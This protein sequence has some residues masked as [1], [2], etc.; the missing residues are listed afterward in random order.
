MKSARPVGIGII[1]CGTIAY[2][3]HIRS[4]AGL[5]N[6]RVT[7]LADPDPDALARAKRLVNAPAFSTVEG[8]LASSAIDAVVIAS[9]TPLHPAH[10]LAACAAGKHVYVEK[11]LAHDAA[12]LSAI[13][14]CIEDTKL[15]IAVGYNLRFHPACQRVRQRLGSGSIG[16]IRAIVSHF[17]E[18]TGWVNMPA[19]KRDREHGGGVLLDLGSHHIDLY[20]WFLRDDVRQISANTRSLHSEQDSAMVS[21]TTRGG[22]DLCGYFAF[23][24]S[25]SHRMI[26]HGSTGVLHLDLHSGVISEERSRR[27]VYGVRRHAVSMNL[28]DLGWQVRKLVQPSYNPSHKAALRAFVDGIIHPA[29]RHPDLATAADGIAALQAVLTAEAGTMATTP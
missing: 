5:C 8:L 1:G 28:P 24:S 2:W 27:S 21:A 16:D 29:R 6:A 10:L 3:T 4:L 25:R 18:P 19:W 23:T 14:G 13:R 11:P 9:P 26:F 12:S 20:R 22:V 15:S 7:G 17:A